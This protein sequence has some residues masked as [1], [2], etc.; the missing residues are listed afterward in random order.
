MSLR[1]TTL[2]V[3][4]CTGLWFEPVQAQA[5]YKVTEGN[6]LDPQTYHGYVLYRNWCARCHG[7][8]AQG[9]AGPNLANSLNQSSK[10]EFMQILF[11]GKKGR[12]G[13]M[14]GFQDNPQIVN[15]REQLYSYLRAR[16]DN[17]IGPV[18]PEQGPK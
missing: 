16:A 7:T 17:A 4:C 9:L 2:L 15:G 10:E 6:K 11:K 5:G 3:L 1:L 8:F 13:V 18:P 12:S 14:P